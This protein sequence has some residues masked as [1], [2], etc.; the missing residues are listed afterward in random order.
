MGIVFLITYGFCGIEMVAC[1]LDD[2]FGD[3]PSDFDALGHARRCFEDCYITI[4]RLDGEERARQL[5]E[6]VR[7]RLSTEAMAWQSFRDVYR[8]CGREGS[9]MTPHSSLSNLAFQPKER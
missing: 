8:E 2:C 4:Y 1:E 7:S 6:K 3:D 5:R 9:F